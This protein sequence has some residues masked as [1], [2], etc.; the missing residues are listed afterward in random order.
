MGSR[1]IPGSR[2]LRGYIRRRDDRL[3]GPGA[4][5]ASGSACGHADRP[6]PGLTVDGYRC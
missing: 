2:G 6:A 1:G 3:A 4:R 5:P